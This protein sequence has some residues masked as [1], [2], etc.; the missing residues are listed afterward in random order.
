MGAGASGP[1]VQARALLALTFLAP[2]RQADVK[3]WEA[4]AAEEELGPW[5][6]GALVIDPRAPIRLEARGAFSQDRPGSEPTID[7]RLRP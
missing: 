2:P 5:L 3:R 4:E 6:C 1:N 7:G